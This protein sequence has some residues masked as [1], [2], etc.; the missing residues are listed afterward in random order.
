MQILNTDA[1]L[2]NPYSQ[3]T[4]NI[5]SYSLQNKQVGDKNKELSIEDEVKKSA[6]QVSISMNAQIVLFTMDSQKVSKDNSTAQN[7]IF[8]FLE[9]KKIEDQLSL[10]DIGYNG[11]PIT[12]LTQDEANELLSD[13]GFFSVEKTSK[14]IS[15]F[16]F[17]FAGYDIDLLEK[18]RQGIV[19]GFEEA[20]KLWSG[21][22]PEISHATQESTLAIIDARIADLKEK[23]KD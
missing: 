23:A 4:S 10:E 20:N 19:K 12:K 22:L 16:V 5:D 9:G 18:G 14:R 15:N 3:H 21:K 2:T 13:D 6:V 17:D 7:E 11:K 8:G 1:N